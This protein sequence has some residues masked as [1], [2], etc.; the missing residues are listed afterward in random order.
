MPPPSWS[1]VNWTN[2]R[3]REVRTGRAACGFGQDVRAHACLAHR[4]MEDCF[5]IVGLMLIV[6]RPA[7]MGL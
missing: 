7:P 2:W 5:L 1:S 4:R 3:R 6:I